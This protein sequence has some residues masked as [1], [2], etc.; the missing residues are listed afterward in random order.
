M[1]KLPDLTCLSDDEK[2]TLISLL[3]EQNQLLR[4]KVSQLEAR[5]KHLEDRLAKNS[6]N[7]SKPPSSD[8][9][10]KPNPKSRREKGKRNSG[11]QKGHVGT[12]LKR[13]KTPDSIV[14]HVA[15]NCGQCG[16]TLERAKELDCEV[17]QVFDIPVLKINVTEHRLH[18]KCCNRCG[19]ITA[20][21][22]PVE[23]YQTVQY[24]AHIKSLMVYMS[25]YQLLPY[26]RLKEFFIDLFGQS[27]SEGTLANANQE[28]HNKLEKT[29]QKI[30][31]LLLKSGVLHADET[32]ARIDKKR[33]WLHVASTKYLTHYGIHTKRGSEAVEEIGLLPQFNGTLV[34]DHLKSYFKYGKSHALCNAHHLRELTFIQER[35]K[36]VWAKD[37][38]TF[39][40]MTKKRVETLYQETGKSLADKELQRLYNKYK[41]IV[42]QGRLE[43]PRAE[44][45]NLSKKGRVKES[46]ARN[47]LNRLREFGGATLAFMFDPR[48]PF[49]NNQA[50][51]D[52]RMTKVKQKIS[53]CFRSEDGAKAFCRVRGYVS[54]MKKNGVS[55]L[56]ALYNAFT[57]KKIYLPSPA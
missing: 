17:R 34:H 42:S 19:S 22:F 32:G 51:R 55:I 29:E 2:D 48:V 24:G 57:N 5:I 14:D 46:D 9:Y 18:R 49:D 44:K 31:K 47:L 36:C 50:E 21:T 13:V 20:G 38:E 33:Y 8:G 39:L 11:G 41:K 27:I 12:T 4:Q 15:S 35:Y 28:M 3:W 45:T 43:C 6:Q 54:T 7:S 1:E 56:T 26:A 25:Q 16:N 40:L 52:I 53:G 37:M 10:N 23:A 30:T